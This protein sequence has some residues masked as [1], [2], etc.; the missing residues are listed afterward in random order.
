MEAVE[1]PDDFAK[2]FYYGGQ[3]QLL[4]EEDLMKLYITSRVEQARCSSLQ[5]IYA[6]SHLSKKADC[7]KALIIGDPNAVIFKEEATRFKAK[8]F[9]QKARSAIL[10]ELLP[11]IEKLIPDFHDREE[12]IMARYWIHLASGFQQFRAAIPQ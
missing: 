6:S 12:E 8:A 10:D 2:V 1:Q 9:L 4:R 11:A 5:S 7:L 3:I